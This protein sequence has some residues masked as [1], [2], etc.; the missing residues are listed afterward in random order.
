[1]TSERISYRFGPLERRGLIGP[2]RLSQFLTLAGGLVAVVV[3]LDAAPS[4]GGVLVCCVLLLGAGAAATLPLSGATLVQWLPVLSRFLA[5]RARGARRQLSDA[6]LRGTVLPAAVVARAKQGTT[7]TG[8][9]GTTPIALP[10]TLRGVALEELPYRNRSVGFVSDH[11]GR[12]LTTLLA[13]QVSGFSLL[14]PPAQEQRLAHWGVILSSCAGTPVRRLQWLERTAPAEGDE[15]AGWLHAERDPELGADGSPL[16]ESYLGLID[17]AAP[18]IHAHE[19]L[20]AVQ[21]DATRVRG[22]RELVHAQLVEQTERVARG[23]EGTGVKVLGALSADQLA[24][25][26]RTAFDPYARPALASLRAA[27]GAAPRASDAAPLTT[28]EAWDHYRCDAAMHATYWISGWPRADVTPTFMGALLAP[29][30]TVRSVAVTFEPIAPER[31]TREVEAAITRDTADRE[32]R[33]RF[34]QTETAR[35]R[36]GHESALRREAELAAGHAE[37][38]FSGYVTVSGR[39]EDELRRACQEVLQ[40][41]ALAR[42]ELRRLY[43]RQ[44][45][46]FTFTLPL[47][48]GLA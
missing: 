12:L 48:R 9:R 6:P 15:L 47:A 46:A 42:I 44:A 20:L 45:Q 40:H 25:T 27:G 8:S 37:V 29:S 43:G 26:W 11:G 30:E 7:K 23:L 16:L 39:T 35:Q 5:R 19:V 33:R 17:A 36:Q 10:R 22:D 21:L 18:V 38:R 2:L 1:M 13:C 32:L 31:S 4:P 28:G 34:G 41:G 24:S 14:D 3:V